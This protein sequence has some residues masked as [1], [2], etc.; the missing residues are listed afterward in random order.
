MIQMKR[1]H[2]KH[3]FISPHM[4]SSL[5]TMSSSLKTFKPSFF[6]LFLS[7]FVT[8]ILG[9]TGV[10]G[11]IGIY[12]LYGVWGTPVFGCTPKAL[13]R[14]SRKVVFVGGALFSEPS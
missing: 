7:F 1:T 6:I 14:R 4:S 12:G 9:V 13:S 8:N 11:V 2:F 5:M 10:I 3:H